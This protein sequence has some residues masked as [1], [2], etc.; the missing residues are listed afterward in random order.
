MFSFYLDGNDTEIHLQLHGDL[1]NLVLE[2][3]LLNDVHE[4][5]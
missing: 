1:H 4:V 2:D 3:T 5:L